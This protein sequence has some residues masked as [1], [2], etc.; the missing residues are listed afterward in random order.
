MTDASSIE[1][2]LVRFGRLPAV[3]LAP[4]AAESA[5]RFGTFTDI[6]AL[7]LLVLLVVLLVIVV[8]GFI[9]LK[10]PQRP[11]VLAAFALIAVIS[12]LYFSLVGQ[13][14]IPSH[15]ANSLRA[16]I[17]NVKV[18]YGDTED[19]GAL[20]TA[21]MHLFVDPGT[22]AFLGMVRT[23]I[24]LAM[25]NAV[26]LFLVANII[27][28]RL[29][30]ALL[31]ALWFGINRNSLHA[32]TSSFPAETMTALYFAV[33]S[34]AALW[35][36]KEKTGRLVSLAA[37]LLLALGL[38]M[39]VMIRAEMAVLAAVT[40]GAILLMTFVPEGGKAAKNEDWD[41]PG[42]FER[43]W[44]YIMIF[45]I[46]AGFLLSILLLIDVIALTPSAA[47]LSGACVKG[48]AGENAV[49]I[50]PF[51]A[52]FLK[53][54]LTLSEFLPAGIVAL[55]VFGFF[56]S[57]VRPFRHL[58]LPIALLI[59]LNVHSH[60][61]A[62]APFAGYSLMTML[63]PLVFFLAIFGWKR[64]EELIGKRLKKGFKRKAAILCMA[65][66]VFVPPP[67][68]VY[69]SEGEGIGRAY[70][71]KLQ[72]GYNQQIELR[73]MLDLIEYYP[74]SI[75]IYRYIMGDEDRV[76]VYGEPLSRPLEFEN[77]KAALSS[78]SGGGFADMELLY[79]RSV[80][81]NREDRE[82]M[83]ELGSCEVL[84]EVDFDSRALYGEALKKR[85]KIGV[86]KCERGGVKREE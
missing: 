45:L 85:I 4:V 63:T 8:R 23:N 84:E 17:P 16:C 73:F 40:T 6:L 22:G 76:F 2:H 18:I 50:N 36:E 72:L 47:E 7:S 67:L 57:I 69:K 3:L 79:I 35:R 74:E 68:G 19:V 15:L 26:L 14:G 53:A 66:I 71:H 44:P 54:P 31:F 33:L 55:A 25:V 21:I 29:L 58:L 65:L 48:G 11:V 32:A 62:D 1:T 86:Y 49:Y 24:W 46:A 20:Y 60:L 56:A 42:L 78:I 81:C 75:F 83:N 61:T 13:Y 9:K 27:T 51:G 80:G 38:I 12:V 30:P 41:G 77:M 59:L 5:G 64:A 52:S 82:C 43:L 37:L 10:P 70:L 28:G 39:L 34:A